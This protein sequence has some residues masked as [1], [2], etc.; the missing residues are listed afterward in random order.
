MEVTNEVSQLQRVLVHRPDEGLERVTPERALDFLYD[1]ITYLPRMQYEHDVFT[2]TLKAVLGAEAV[3]DTQKLL[4]QVLEFQQDVR[5][6]LIKRITT[7]ERCDEDD[8]KELEWLPNDELTQTLFTGVLSQTGKELFPPL[9]NYVFTRDIGVVINDHLLICQA[10][11]KART[12]ENILSRAIYYYHPLFASFHENDR[13]IDLTEQTKDMTLEGGDVMM[14]NS[15][16]ILIGESERTSDEAI[17]FV[18]ETLFK[19][20]IVNHVVQIK[21]PAN[22]SYMHIDTVFT[23]ISGDEFVLY[24]PLMCNPD[25]VHLTQYNRDGSQE[26]FPELRSFLE[27]KIP[28]V[29]L[30]ACGNRFQHHDEREQWTDGCNLVALRPGLAIAYDRNVYTADA[31]RDRGYTIMKAETFLR[32]YRQKDLDV[33]HLGKFIFTLPSSEL[34][35]ARGG[36]HCMTFPIKRAF[37]A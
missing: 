36:P 9:P 6:K 17:D 12:R 24:E 19:K 21:I 14:L 31:L 37:H 13:I 10:A 5:K 22:R 3:H 28:T 4:F 29:K 35:R 18:R 34:S 16:T 26:E 11:K 8:I 1:D 33:E 27:D 2:D 7:I 20:G 15:D 23:Q 30:I 32:L 25:L